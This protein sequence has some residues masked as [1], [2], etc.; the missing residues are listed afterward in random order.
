LIGRG[1]LPPDT[2]AGALADFC[3]AIMQGGLVTAKIKKDS[4]PFRNA[5]D[6]TMVYLRGMTPSA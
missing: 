2:D 4:S 1:E 5:V 6:H 3:Y